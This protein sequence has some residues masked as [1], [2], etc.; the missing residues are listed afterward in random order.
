M[1]EGGVFID[2]ID[3]IYKKDLQFDYERLIFVD[4][5]NSLYLEKFVFLFVSFLNNESVIFEI[6]DS[7]LLENQMKDV[8]VG[9]GELSN[10]LNVE[11]FLVEVKSNEVF[12][13]WKIFEKKFKK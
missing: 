9:Q 3:G 6:S 11:I 4:Y 5:M 7:K 12:G 2:Q 13:G 8:F 10:E 1:S